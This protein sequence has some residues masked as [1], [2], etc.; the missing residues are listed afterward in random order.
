MHISDAITSVRHDLGLLRADMIQRFDQGAAVTAAIQGRINHV[1]TSIIA[2][3][4]LD[5]L[6]NTVTQSRNAI[7]AVSNKVDVCHTG[8]QSITTAIAACRQTVLDCQQSLLNRVSATQNAMTQAIS[9]SRQELC[10]G[11]IT[12]RDNFIDAV[13]TAR[14]EIS[15][16]SSALSESVASFASEVR[17]RLN[18][19]CQSIINQTSLTHEPSGDV[20]DNKLQE[21]WGLIEQKNA[22]IHGL[23]N[24]LESTITETAISTADDITEKVMK[25]VKVKLQE[26]QKELCDMIQKVQLEMRAGH[27]NSAARL[28]NR[29][30]GCCAS[31]FVKLRGV[32]NL[33]IHSLPKTY[34]G[35]HDLHGEHRLAKNIIQRKRRVAISSLLTV[36]AYRKHR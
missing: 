33:P 4:S 31:T 6:N 23:P 25:E 26:L 7:D 8:I 18:R 2:H 17:Q 16:G 15:A 13:G 30:S 27:F 11:I 20:L 32:D 1:E 21:L 10:K 14:K 35:L 34:A 22:A 3:C 12:L 28:A 9:D 24:Q 36:S 19:T 29:L 5:A